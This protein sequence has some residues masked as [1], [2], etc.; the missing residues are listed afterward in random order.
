[1]S[2]NSSRR[3]SH[4]RWLV[5]YADF[6]T[7]LFAFFAMMYAISSVD[8]HKLAQVAGGLQAAFDDSARSRSLAGGNGVL[9]EKGP[10]VAAPPL[11]AAAF[12][13]HVARELATELL[14]HQIE[15]TLESRGLVLSI[16]EAGTF[17][18]GS[19]E[20][21]EAA[22]TLIG[23]VATTIA[24]TPN[25]IRVEGHTDDV[26]IHT[27]RFSSN[28]DLSTARATRVVEF[29]SAQVGIAPTR[30]SAAGYGE[31]H[32]RVANEGA[33]GRA[34]NRRVDIVVLNDSTS[35]AEEPSAGKGRR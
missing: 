12:S 29:L 20:L 16:P 17:A 14:A 19:D 24:N 10:R 15:I 6:M 9:P 18:V 5:S 22:R 27:Q 3:P 7:L 21:S 35:T 33:A 13:A 26:P 25:S 23:R 1:M 2:Q 32:P 31:F 11:D 8:A 28:W 4:E 30:L 34:R